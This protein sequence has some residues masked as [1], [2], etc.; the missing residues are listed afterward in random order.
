ML[1]IKDLVLDITKFPF[2]FV[3]TSLLSDSGDLKICFQH[4][5]L[6]HMKYYIKLFLIVKRFD[7]LYDLLQ[8]F[9]LMLFF[10]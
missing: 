2:K 8:R 6:Y 1:Q 3:V 4:L 10:G 7:N 9:F 5:K